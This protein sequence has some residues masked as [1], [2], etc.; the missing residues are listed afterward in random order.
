MATIIL[1]VSA[2]CCLRVSPNIRG[3][4]WLGHRLRPNRF[5][6][7]QTWQSAT[8]PLILLLINSS[9]SFLANHAPS[10]RA[11][12]FHKLKYETFVSSSFR[13]WK[14]KRS[15]QFKQLTKL[16]SIKEDS[17]HRRESSSALRKPKRIE[18]SAS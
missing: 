8:S 1:M 15:E 6:A 18:Y 14:R 2:S 16:P 4:C 11:T 17:A 10:L 3:L 9:L 7:C 5:R 13:R 12:T